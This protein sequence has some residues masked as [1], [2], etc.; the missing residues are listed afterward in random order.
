[1]TE[2]RRLPST[3]DAPPEAVA[4]VESIC[5][6]IG[7]DDALAGRITL[8]AAE[9]AA[10]AAEHGNG[11]REGTEVLVEVEWD[12]GLLQ[13]S[14]EDEGAGVAADALDTAALPEDPLD[15]GGRGLFLMSALA[16]EASVAAGGRRV[17]MR[18]RLR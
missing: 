13:L 10:N 6:R 16:D 15:T 7:L 4:F 11:Y 1:M 3:P 8:A 14:V 2:T 17:V 18:W 9:A 12:A 5:E